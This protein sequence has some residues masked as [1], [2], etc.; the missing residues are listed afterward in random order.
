M[1]YAKFTVDTDVL[2]KVELNMELDKT[3]YSKNNKSFCSPQ[4]SLS[5]WYYVLATLKY[6]L[7]KFC[8]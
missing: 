2:F 3:Q 5:F 4:N 8:N 7:K 1:L 6:I